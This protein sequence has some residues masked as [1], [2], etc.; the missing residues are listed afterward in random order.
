MGRG[1]KYTETGPTQI[2]DNVWAF[3]WEPGSW[4][5]T[6]TGV[7]VD[8][9]AATMVLDTVWDTVRAEQIAAETAELV[10]DAPITEVINT[11]S[12]GDHW[13]GNDTVPADAR[14]TTS[15]AS[16][17]AMKEETPPAGVDAF[18]TLGSL[19][20]RVPGP[21]GA[22]GGYMNRIRGGAA[23]PRTRPRLPDHTFESTETITVGHRDVQLRFLGPAHTEGDLIAHVPDCGVVFT[24][25][26]LFIESTPVLWFGP[27][28]NW[29]DALNHLISLDAA[30]CLP[31]HGPQCGVAEIRELREYWLWVDAAGRE[32]Y[33]AGVG[34]ATAARNMLSSPEF[35]RFAHWDS[36]ERLVLSMS[37]LYRLWHGEPAAPPTLARRAKACADA[38]SLLRAGGP[39]GVRL[40]RGYGR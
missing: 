2:G 23:F 31:C 38:G 32:Q 19:V 6:N 36:P 1:A 33:K 37:T 30:V 12:D 7:L 11:H 40:R 21:V 3:M 22:M 35:R 27:L 5:E 28:G 26:L 18:A 25:D 15:A 17:H 9:G 24:G 13:W 39:T 10:G 8:P 4:G 20:R 34:S 16:L 14:I 29:I